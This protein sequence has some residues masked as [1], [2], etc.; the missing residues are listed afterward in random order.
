M[1]D[2]WPHRSNS[3][4]QSIDTDKEVWSVV[5]LS[6]GHLNGRTDRDAVK[7]GNSGVPRE[8]CIRWS[9]DTSKERAILWVIR[10]VERH[11]ES[12]LRCT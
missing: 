7:V 6:V 1:S 11:C 5:C 3:N 12:L 8:P 10:P 2:Y 9:P 4:M